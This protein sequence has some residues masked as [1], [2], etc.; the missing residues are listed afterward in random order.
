MDNF[1]PEEYPVTFGDATKIFFVVLIIGWFIDSR[2]RTIDISGA[3]RAGRK[4]KNS[5]GG[6]KF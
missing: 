4:P 6:F 3:R 2:L 5:S 1:R